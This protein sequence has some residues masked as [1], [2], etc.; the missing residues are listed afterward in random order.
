MDIAHFTFEPARPVQEIHG[1]A[2]IGTHDTGARIL[3]LK[4][5]DVNK[6]FAIAFKTP[7]T[8][9]TGV[10]HIL[11]H[12][13][14]C[15]SER[16]PVKE[17]FVNLLKTSMQTFLN[18]LTFSD[19]TMYPVASTNEQD[20]ANL[21][22]VY[23][24]AVFHPNIYHRPQ[25]FEQEGWHYELDAP[26]DPLTING[27]VYNEMKGAL[28][29][30]EERLFMG[31]NRALFPATCYQWESG[32]TPAAIPTLTYQEFL[33]TH[34]R[35]YQASNATVIL[36]GDCDIKARLAQIDAAL[37]AAPATAAAPNPL[38]LQ[39]PVR[40]RDT[41]VAMACD[42]ANACVGVG[43]VFAT[44]HQRE[45]VLAADILIDTLMGSNEAP[46]KRAILDAGLGDDANAY[47]IDGVAQPYVVFVLKGA[48]PGAASAFRDLIESTAA[49]LVE[50]HLDEKRLE[51]SLS[52]A[53]FNLRE[54]DFGYPDGVGLAMCALSG[55]LYRD[56]DALAY[57]QYEDACA[58][59]RS[60]LGTGYFETLLREIMVDATHAALVE[61]VPTQE[62]EAELQAQEL[63]EYKASLPKEKLE[64]LVAH[65]QALHEA[66]AAPDS[67]EALATLPQL[68]LSDIGPMPAAPART[69]VEGASIPGVAY[70]L[71]TH[72]ITYVYT[73][74]SLE[75]LSFEELPY[76]ALAAALLGRLDT[77]HYSAS[78]LDTQIEASLGNLSFF[79]ETYGEPG[80]LAAAHPKLVVAASALAEK[81]AQLARLPQEIWSTTNFNDPARIQA[82][83]TQ[84]RVGQEQSI[85]NA[86][87]ATALS[88]SASYYHAPH[89]VAQ[90][91][92]GLDFYFFIK[93]LL[94]HFDE[95][96]GDL[97]ARLQALLP[98]LFSRP[99]ASFSISGTPACIKDYVALAGDLSLSEGDTTG[100]HLELPALTPRN[101]AFVVPSDVCYVAQTVAAPATTSYNGPWIVAG[102]ALSLTYLWNEVRVLGGAY[103]C[104]FRM[105][106]A[107]LMQF[108]SY[109][110]PAVD[111]TCKRFDAAGAWLSTWEPAQS[112][113]DGFIISSVATIDAPKKP[114][115]TQRMY[116]GLYFGG[117]DASWRE[118]VRTQLL[119]TTA[120]DVLA[121]APTLEA[122]EHT[123]CRCV[124]GGQAQIEAATGTYAITNVL[125]DEKI[126][127]S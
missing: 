121:L 60:L 35:H 126:A 115:Q 29:E 58:H 82:I 15:G 101:E 90:H 94:A 38:E 50:A 76:A 20:L 74:F 83:L 5:A 95:R 43:Y 2:Y 123:A 91:T 24:D 79:I 25:I 53:E 21:M 119:H 102:R 18:A 70:A 28:S 114:A 52:Q 80:N 48:K 36:Y 3:W 73:Y 97:I 14:L 19:K 23:L 85:A 86:G 72:N 125:Q 127:R 75:H 106:P 92:Q 10:F 13:V 100:A 32:G 42:P 17:P 103:G 96:S 11:E 51:A 6:A 47:L 104:G 49:S 98:R 122:A 37:S 111:P 108:Y 59:L 93:D 56:S 55:W 89:L 117:R 113:L 81:T 63:A 77:A 116:D 44:S 57:I 62:G 118:T 84:M 112:D 41:Q 26:G 107:N 4:N 16:Y 109:R 46:L 8:T 110:D 105:T 71:D 78:E 27:V 12:S 22:A 69:P 40:P 54:G 1:E 66:Q 34:A 64:E 120:Q 87:H 30:P 88:R 99:G 31:I 9:D 61:V 45:R 7:P 39:G 67:P 68:T 124:V 33:D 65:T